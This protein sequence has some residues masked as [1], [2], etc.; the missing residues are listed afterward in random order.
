MQYHEPLNE[1]IKHYV[2]IK[3]LHRIFYELFE[4]TENTKLLE[5]TANDFFCYLNTALLHQLN[6]D[7]CKITDPFDKYGKN[8][9][10]DLFVKLNIEE[11]KTNARIENAWL[12]I[13]K[14]RKYIVPVRNKVVAHNDYH[15][16][17]SFKT[18]GG[19]PEGEDIKF[20]ENIEIILNELKLII[21]GS[22]IGD[23]C[24]GLEG[25]V[26]DFL[27]Y[28]RYGKG[29]KEMFEKEK[30]SELFY[31]ICRYMGLINN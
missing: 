18:L 7:F 15:V 29:M 19:F 5:E 9:T 26:L 16:I 6:L 28:L 3:Q 4:N 24:L 11:I 30:E 8:L 23:I 10:I 14:F 21:D 12:E 25:D 22:I 2:W 13:E 1:L 27:K 20:L 17:M 31:K